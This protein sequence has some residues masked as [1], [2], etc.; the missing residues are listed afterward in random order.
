[1]V[2]YLRVGRDAG[3]VSRPVAAL[4]E[5]RNYLETESAVINLERESAV[6]DRRYSYLSVLLKNPSILAQASVAAS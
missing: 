4:C 6:I 2:D 5:R 3:L 1:M